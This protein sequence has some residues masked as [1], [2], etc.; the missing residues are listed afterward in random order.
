MTL[1]IVLLSEALLHKGYM[2][3]DYLRVDHT[4]LMGCA[5]TPIFWKKRTLYEDFCL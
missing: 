3:L 5:K 2:S 1:R 4:L